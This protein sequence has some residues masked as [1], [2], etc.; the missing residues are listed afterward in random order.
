MAEKTGALPAQGATATE[1]SWMLW[2]DPLLH[3]GRESQGK[4]RASLLRKARVYPSQHSEGR[5]KEADD[6]E[7]PHAL[8]SL[9][10]PASTFQ[11][12]RADWH[13]TGK[14]SRLAQARQANKD[15]GEK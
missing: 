11:H 10:L 4:H 5:W 13:Q 9:L 3:K 2:M 12:E 1:D 8:V 7:L 6:V 14:W 15:I